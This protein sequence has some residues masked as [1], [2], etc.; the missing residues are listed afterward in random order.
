MASLAPFI[1]MSVPRLVTSCIACCCLICTSWAAVYWAFS[2]S[3]R[4]SSSLPA[5]LTRAP[6]ASTVSALSS[7]FLP[8]FLLGDGVLRGARQQAPFPPKFPGGPRFFYPHPRR[9]G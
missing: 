2:L 1:A 5:A 8:H 3:N 6:A 7:L 9:G 4:A